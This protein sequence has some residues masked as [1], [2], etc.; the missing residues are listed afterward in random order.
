MRTW[1]L[2]A[3]ALL[4]CPAPPAGGHAFLDHAEPRVGSTVEAPPTVTLV[5]T[6]PIE[7][8]FSRLDLADAKGG[9]V[10]VG[11]ARHP[12]PD[13]LEVA[14]PSLPPGEYTVHWAVVSIDTHPTEGRFTFSVKEPR[15]G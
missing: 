10:E 13:R 11:P 14:L 6:E 2:A 3:L 5:F 4:V 12:S 15:R 7:A 9:K 8:A 1:L